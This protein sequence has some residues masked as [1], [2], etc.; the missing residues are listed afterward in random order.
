MVVKYKKVLEGVTATERL[1]RLLKKALEFS[2]PIPSVM[3]TAVDQNLS[4]LRNQVRSGSDLSLEDAIST[5]N[6]FSDART[7]LFESSS[8]NSSL[9]FI[10]ILVVCAMECVFHRMDRDI[11]PTGTEPL[12]SVQLEEALREESIQLQF[13]PPPDPTDGDRRT[14]VQIQF[15]LRMQKLRLR[16]EERKYM[17]ITNNLSSMT[18]P[19]SDDTT[20]QS[21]MYATSIGLNMI[22]APISFGIFM[23]FFAGSLLDYIWPPTQQPTTTDIKKVIAGVISGVLM[24]FIEMLL[25]V[26]RTHELDKALVKKKKKYFS[27]SQHPFG[28]YTA[29][30]AK[31][32]V[33]RS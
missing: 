5:M 21:M 26:I 28:H 33:D 30:S 6:S 20:T 14:P 9:D 15:Q 22:V 16:N 10:P 32:Y 8:T 3:H 7:A 25:F 27:S 19:K 23:Y 1:L 13:T 12:L 24:L 29:K 18:Q 31:S 17:K 11:E 4:Q 2:I